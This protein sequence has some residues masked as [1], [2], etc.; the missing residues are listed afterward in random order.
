M[1]TLHP[2]TPAR[3][4]LTTSALISTF[5][6]FAADWSSSHVFNPRWPPHAKFHNGQ[7]MSTGAALGVLTAYY[8][9]RRTPLP[10]DSLR[11]A[12]I[13]GSL[14]FLTALTG[15]LYPGAE[16]VDPEFRGK[17]DTGFPQAVP[18][19]VMG[20]LPWVGFGVAKW[21]MGM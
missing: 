21:R 18:F 17:Y 4:I 9:W 6:P 7:T 20:G 14:Y 3:L 13:M 11:T 12:A 19:M 5:G 16:G 10:M 1:P 2:L 8:T 15:V